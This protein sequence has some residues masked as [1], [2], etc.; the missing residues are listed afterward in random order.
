MQ[1]IRR[2]S[3]KG[4]GTLG[5]IFWSLLLL[6]VVVAA[7]KM[8]PVKVAT[9][10]FHDFMDDQA[11]GA[12]RRS[13]ESIRKAIL[14]KARDLDLPVDPK[15]LVVVLTRD[16]IKMEVE[17]T[18]PVDFPGFTYDWDFHYAEKFPIFIF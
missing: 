3:Q 15:D 1:L 11:R 14:K 6:V 8:V 13:E 5:C 9:A 18:V 4:E 2:S 10:E 7:W 12:D 17:Y 16:D